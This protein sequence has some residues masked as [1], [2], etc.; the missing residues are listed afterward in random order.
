MTTLLVWLASIAVAAILVEIAGATWP[1]I[2][3]AVVR[4]T[5]WIITGRATRPSHRANRK[6][7]AS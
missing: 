7:A 2:R 3:D 4:T 6:E 5:R 1:T